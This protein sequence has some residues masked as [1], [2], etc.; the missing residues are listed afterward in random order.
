MNGD[1]H[2]YGEMR[3]DLARKHFEDMRRLAIVCGCD[4]CRLAELLIENDRLMVL[5]TMPRRAE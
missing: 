3:D 4:W 2:I 1:L 5:A